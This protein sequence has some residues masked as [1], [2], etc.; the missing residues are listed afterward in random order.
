MDGDWIKWQWWQRAS[1]YSVKKIDTIHKLRF[2]LESKC[3]DQVR[4]VV[5]RRIH[6]L[7]PDPDKPSSSDGECKARNQ[8][9][10]AI[11]TLV[12]Q[13]TRRIKGQG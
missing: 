11:S 12:K 6:A 4:S 13:Q 5:F 2:G 10:G 8:R 3:L 7:C 1:G 9:Q